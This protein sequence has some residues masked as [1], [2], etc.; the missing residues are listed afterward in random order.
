MIILGKPGQVQSLLLKAVLQTGVVKNRVKA[1]QEMEPCTLFNDIRFSG[2]GTVFQ[3]TDKQ[4][5]FF[6]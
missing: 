1:Q 3:G 2:E 4:V 5:T 6:R